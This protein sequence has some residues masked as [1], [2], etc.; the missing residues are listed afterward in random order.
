[1]LYRESKNFLTSDNIDFIEKTILGNNFPLYQMPHTVSDNYQDTLTHII[2]TRPEDSF[3]PRIRSAYY[4]PVINII[5]SFLKS[6]SITDIKILRLAINFTYNN[7]F[8]KCTAHT[9]HDYDHLQLIIYLNDPLDK[10]SKTVVLDKNKQIIKEIYPEKYK[11]VLFEGLP[12]Y[13]HYP[14]KGNRIILIATFEYG[15]NR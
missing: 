1:M 4:D 7:G 3:T 5:K 14:K 2:L 8:E 11:G 13:L 10:E 6:L 12:H 9:D 15:N